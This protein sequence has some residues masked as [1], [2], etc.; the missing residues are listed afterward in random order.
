MDRREFMK[1]CSTA[2]VA[3]TLTSGLPSIADE[4]K[5]ANIDPEEFA[6]LAYEHFIP[7]KLTCC[8]SILL[9]G[10]EVLGIKSELVPDITLGL[11]GGVGFQ[12]E[13]CGVI[14][15]AAMV[16]S[17][18]IAEKETNYDKKK[19]VTLN[20]VGQ[21]HNSFKEKFGCTDCQTLSGLDLTTPE[22]KKKLAEG[23]KAQVCSNYVTEGAKMLALKLQG[24]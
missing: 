11:A 7:G 6:K 18:A 20:V 2:L 17:L 13:I 9:A 15:G 5:Q 21:L 1:L 12:G 10:C 3:G 8:E 22:G 19:M 4:L 24:I 16:L 23:V 14:T